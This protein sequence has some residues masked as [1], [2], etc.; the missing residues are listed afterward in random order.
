MGPRVPPVSQRREETG[1][2]G[3]CKTLR[4]RAERAKEEKE[5]KEE[6]GERKKGGDWADNSPKGEDGNLICF[7]FI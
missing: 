5:G 7:L 6:V 2:G 4:E 3:G 1:W